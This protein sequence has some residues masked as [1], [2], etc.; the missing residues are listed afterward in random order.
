MQRQL[1]P[2]T[3][4]PSPVPLNSPT[5]TNVPSPAP[6]SPTYLPDPEYDSDLD[7][8][9]DVHDEQHNAEIDLE[10]S[11]F[12]HEIETMADDMWYPQNITPHPSTPWSQS[13]TAPY[14]DNDGISPGVPAEDWSPSNNPS[15]SSGNAPDPAVSPDEE[16]TPVLSFRRRCPYPGH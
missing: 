8:T 13:S 3:Q 16:H 11:G 5:P 7:V 15:A 14:G 6:D 12:P 1:F 4:S 2:P 9:D 10:A